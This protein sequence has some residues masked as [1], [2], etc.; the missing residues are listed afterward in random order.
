[1]KQKLA[2]INARFDALKQDLL[3]FLRGH[4]AA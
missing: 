1:M 3:P 2:I 4:T